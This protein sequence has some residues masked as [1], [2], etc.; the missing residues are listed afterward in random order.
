MKQ[1]QTNN[2]FL[3]AKVQLRAET[4]PDIDKINV[5]DAYSGQGTIWQ[6]IKATSD[7]DINITRIDTEDVKGVYLKGD[8]LK[9]LNAIDL[10]IYNIIDL[11]AYGIPYKQLQALFNRGYKGIVYITFIQTMYGQLSKGILNSLGYTDTMI[12]KIPTLFNKYGFTKFKQYL[13]TKGVTKIRHISFDNKH[14]IV[15]KT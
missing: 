4:L 9:F 2:S 5:L 11:D 6:Q 14:Y 10:S 13:A 12:D 3:D 8:N 7:K 15:I 1:A